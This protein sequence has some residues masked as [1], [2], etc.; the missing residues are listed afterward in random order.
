VTVEQHCGAFNETS[1][2]LAYVSSAFA[3]APLSGN[4][5]TA[6]CTL[7]VPA[8]ADGTTVA[9]YA[10]GLCATAAGTDR[11]GTGTG[12]GC[13]FA[14]PRT[15]RVYTPGVVGIQRVAAVKVDDLDDWVL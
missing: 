2:E 4:T 14:P 13:S 12:T 3:S 7:A 6:Q 5:K 9:A 11:T 8:C 1:Q 15:L 10:V